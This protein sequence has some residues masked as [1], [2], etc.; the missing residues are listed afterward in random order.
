MYISYRTTAYQ[1]LG[2]FTC[3]IFKTTIILQTHGVQRR[4][5]PFRLISQPRLGTQGFGGCLTVAN[6]RD[7]YQHLQSFTNRLVPISQ[8]SDK[9]RHSLTNFL[10]LY[11]KRI[12]QLEMLESLQI[13]AIHSF[14]KGTYNFPFMF[15]RNNP[16]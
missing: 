16:T 14:V 2:C 10:F 8:E 4:A 13:V 12:Q 15:V 1:C 9:R 3:L 6:G 7:E 5:A 11:E